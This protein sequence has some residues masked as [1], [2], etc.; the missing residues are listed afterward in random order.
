MIEKL[1]SFSSTKYLLEELLVLSAFQRS[2]K[3]EYNA[4]GIDIPDWLEQSGRAIAASI[5]ERVRDEL[6]RKL[7]SAKA[8]RASLK[9][10]DERRKEADEE[11]AAI[12]AKLG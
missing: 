7:A 11:I 3:G 10:A 8:R 1:K 6:E 9:T 12:T 4:T 5:K 2:V